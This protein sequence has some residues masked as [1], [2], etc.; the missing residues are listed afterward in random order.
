MERKPRTRL[1]ILFFSF[2]FLAITGAI[3]A[4]VLMANNQ[5]NYKRLARALGL[6]VT[7][8]MVIPKPGTMETFKGKRLKDVTLMLDSYVFMPEIKDRSSVFLRNMRRDGNTL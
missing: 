6:P 5:R 3:A 4:T 7:E 1:G 2:F 8:T